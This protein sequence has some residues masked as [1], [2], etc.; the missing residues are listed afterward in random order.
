MASAKPQVDSKLAASQPLQADIHQAEL[1]DALDKAVQVSHTPDPLA[2]M[3]VSAKSPADNI[4]AASQSEEV[5]LAQ[6]DA[7]EIPAATQSDVQ[8]EEV[9]MAPHTQDPPAPTQCP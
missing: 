6:S 9:A 4:S 1:S 8:D 7:Q 3:E 5:H 2:P